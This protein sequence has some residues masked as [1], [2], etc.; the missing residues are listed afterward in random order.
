LSKFGMA[1]S[2]LNTKDSKAHEGN[3]I[4]LIVIL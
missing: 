4:F 2:L 3:Y 1:T